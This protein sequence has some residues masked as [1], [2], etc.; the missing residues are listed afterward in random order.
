MIVSIVLFFFIRTDTVWLRIVSRV[1]LVPFVAGIS[2]E[3]IRYAGKHDN[4]LVNIISAPGILMQ[5]ITTKNPDDE[6][7]EVAIASLNAVLEV[8]PEDDY[9]SSCTK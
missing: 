8:E 9:S 5:F 2:Y 4:I 3:F 6:M 7:L 1:I